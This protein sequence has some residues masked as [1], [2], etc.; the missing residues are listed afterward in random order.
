MLEPVGVPLRTA[1]EEA[2]DLIGRCRPQVRRN[3]DL[4]DAYAFAAR[5]IHSIGTRALMARR[6]RDA[7]QQAL[8]AQEDRTRQA[9]VMT[10]MT[11]ILELLA[12]GRQNAALLKS[13]HERLW[14]AENRP[15]WLSN[16]QAQYDQDLRAW[17]TRADELRTS[18]VMFRNGRRLPPAE[19][20][21]LGAP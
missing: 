18:T 2:I 13:E 4:L 21:G 10:S 14:L 5:R 1:A 16:I 19:Q 11:G 9:Q 17:M 8:A 7:Y 20:V 12:Q 15:Y 3:A 6:I